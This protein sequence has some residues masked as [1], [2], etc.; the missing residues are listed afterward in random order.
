MPHRP[1]SSQELFQDLPMEHLPKLFS[2]DVRGMSGGKYLHWE[3]IRVRQPPAGFTREEWWLATKIKRA[4]LREELPFIDKEGRPFAFTDSGELYRRLREIDRDASGQIGF[5]STDGVHERSG[6]RYLVSSLIEEAITSSQLE[7]AATTRLVAKE[8]LRSGRSP[9]DKSEQMI[10][11]NY[12]AMEFLRDHQEDDLTA[13]MLLELQT[14]LTERTLD[15]DYV[16][17]FRRPQDNVDVVQWDGTVVHVP[18]KA[19]QL[20]DR[21]ERLLAFANE[22][23]GGQS[24]HPFVRAVVLHFMVGYDHPFVDGNGR[25]A[26]GLFYW[27]MAR[28]GYWLTEYLSISTIIRKAPAQY[29]RAYVYSE[30]DDNDLSYFLEFNL[31]VMLQAIRA[32]HAYLSRKAKELERLAKVIRGSDLAVVFNHRQIALLAHMVRHPDATYTISGHQRS[33][34]VTYQ[35]ARTDLIGLADFGFLDPYKAGRQLNY[36]R[37]GDVEANVRE[38]A[39]LIRE[40]IADGRASH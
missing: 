26:R 3:D 12:H 16:G 1:P 37:T 2:A 14:M 9:R 20:G 21:I 8:M 27:S 39:D 19:E 15:S 6:E 5:A 38:L 7:G 34:N 33:H 32:L 10:V 29:I 18:P 40:D 30:T 17:R 13:D 11:N 23:D 36:R 4:S 28:S 25:T 31:R 35:T 24:I 22:N